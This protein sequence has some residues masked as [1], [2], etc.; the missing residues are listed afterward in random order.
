[1]RDQGHC[2]TGGWS[3]HG[4]VLLSMDMLE[5][6][7]RRQVVVTC[8]SCEW[9]LRATSHSTCMPHTPVHHTPV[10]Y[11]PHARRSHEPMRMRGHVH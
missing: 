6:K 8:V 5:G 11:A 1:M 10:L 2:R 4:I 7:E 9:T 3:I